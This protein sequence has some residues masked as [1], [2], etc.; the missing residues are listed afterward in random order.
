MELENKD[1]RE[2]VERVGDGEFS[3][4]VYH[5]LEQL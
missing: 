2:F 5:I 3:T 4:T 1:H